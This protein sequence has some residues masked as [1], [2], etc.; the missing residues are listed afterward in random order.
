MIK[1]FVRQFR[2]NSQFRNSIFILLGSLS[3]AGFG[4][5][6]WT[7]V[8]RLF[9]ATNVGLATTLLSMSSL[10]SLISLAGFDVAFIRFLPHARDKSSYINSGSI[11]VSI[12][13]IVASLIV[14]TFLVIGGGELAPILHDPMNWVWFC[15]FTWL[16]SLNLLTNAPFLASRRASF[17]FYISTIFSVIKVGLPLLVIG[18]S[19]M[20]IF[21][22]AGIAQLIG[23]VLSYAALMRYLDYK[24]TLRV[25]RTILKKTRRYT[26]SVYVASLLNLLPPTILPLL[27]TNS[28]GSAQAA[29]YYMAFTI[30]TVLYTIAY[31]AM[32]SAF[33][34]GSHETDMIHDHIVKGLRQT[35]LLM[36][37][38]AALLF[39][40]APL[41]LHIFGGDYST[42]GAP[43]LQLFAVGSIFVAI[44]SALGS[45]FK[46]THMMTSLV[47][48]NI[49]YLVTIL[50][51]SVWLIQPLGITAIGWAWIIGN[52]VA[53]VFG[54]GSYVLR[55]KKS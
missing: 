22:V 23:T 50:L 29:Y 3:V 8:A 16:S 19:A 9:P 44:Y 13:S 21:N 34:E 42:H 11:I 54:V 43:L 2:T 28:L 6:F 39:F 24:P 51:V 27:I 49:L 37:P 38:A 26:F 18:G 53:S 40:G 30:A 45:L 41:L 1:K 36:V 4:F 20:A 31:S 48:M 15:I 12:I 33:A 32:Q 17:V 47:L 10:I 25:D 55:R 7:L 46:I 5:I 14:L 35:A 52:L